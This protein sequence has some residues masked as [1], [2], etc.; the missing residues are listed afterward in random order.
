MMGKGNWIVLSMAAVFVVS[1]PILAASRVDP[2]LKQIDTM[3]QLETDD[4][5]QVELIQQK[6]DEGTK[7]VRSTFF[8]RQADDSFLM[9]MTYPELERGNGY[10]KQGDNYWMYR[11]NTRTFQH[12]ARGE[13]IAGTDSSAE[14]FED[15]KLAEKYRAILDGAGKEKMTET[16][17]GEVPVYCIELE[18][19]QDNTVYPKKIYWVR[20][21]NYLP[22]KVQSFSLSGKLMQTAYFLK[23]IQLQGK[24]VW[25]KGVF[26]DEFEKGNKTAVE[27]KNLSTAKVPDHYF[28]KGYLESLSK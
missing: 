17:L 3:T 1:Q 20:Q 6:S 28:T 18:A 21:D 9:V 5:S 24:Y 2:V 27:F 22:L 15:L 26:V 16:K 8:H 19:K 10:L 7:V 4:A 25:V 23:Y 12:I 13:N 11:R 14:D